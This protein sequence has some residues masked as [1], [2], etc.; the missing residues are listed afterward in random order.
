MDLKGKMNSHYVKNSMQYLKVKF[1]LQL[2]FKFNVTHGGKDCPEDSD[3]PG[4]AAVSPIDIELSWILIMSRK[5]EHH[6]LF[7]WTH[8]DNSC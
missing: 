7:L 8:N 4:A 6:Y 2:S 1:N 5:I 3:D